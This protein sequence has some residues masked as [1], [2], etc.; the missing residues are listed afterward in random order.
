MQFNRGDGTFLIA[1]AGFSPSRSE[2][3]LLAERRRRTPPS[4][5]KRFEVRPRPVSK[6]AAG[7]WR[8]SGRFNDLTDV[9]AAGAR[10]EIAF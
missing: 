1:E 6:I 4:D 9:D 2:Q 10:V 5:I 8:Y 3:V 7:F